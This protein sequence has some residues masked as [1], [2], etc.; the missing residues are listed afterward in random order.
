MK[1]VRIKTGFV[2]IV[3]KNQEY[4][5]ALTKGTHLLGF[6]EN[7]KMYNITEAFVCEDIE[8]HLLLEDVKLAEM[9]HVVDVKASELMLVYKDGVFDHGL[10][11]GKYTYWK[12]HIKYQFKVLNK[13][14]VEKCDTEEELLAKTGVLDAYVETLSVA[15]H[16]LALV[17]KNGHFSHSLT[18]G[19][20]MHCK[21]YLDFQFTVCDISKIDITEEVDFKAMKQ[22]GSV[23]HIRTVKVES[24]EKAILFANGKQHAVLS[25][26]L[27]H[28]WKNDIELEVRKADMRVRQLEVSG[29]EILTKDKAAIRINYDAQYQVVDVEKAL[30]N[31]KDYEKQLYVSVQLALREYVGMFTLDELLEKKESA[32]EYIGAALAARA[33]QL[34]VKVHD[35][36]IRDII[37]NGDMKDIMN[38]VLIAHKRAQANTISRREETASTR[39][40][41]NTAKLMEDNAMLFKLKE[42]EYVE[43][44][45]DKIN[46]ITVSGG[47]QV[48]EQLRMLFGTSE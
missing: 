1:R 38:Q 18:A 42:M 47:N 36:G 21:G 48:A 39:S 14:S 45:A 27:Y 5:R 41:L 16:E 30:L 44:I 17:Y 46:N 6:G 23:H 19:Y 11:H 22:V 34:G 10:E 43:K 13:A 8:I 33:D 28:Y 29:Q 25:A 26:G 7:V 35:S 40:L 4:R 2:G 9:L 12:S 37:L 20:Y 24:H 3:T 32:A 31:S 15:D